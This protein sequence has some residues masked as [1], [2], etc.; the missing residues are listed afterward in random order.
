[1]AYEMRISDWSSDV[2][3]SDLPVNQIA[4][5]AISAIRIGN[6]SVAAAPFTAITSVARNRYPKITI[7]AISDSTQRQRAIADR[8]IRAT[9]PSSQAGSRACRERVW[10]YGS[11]SL[12]AGCIKKTLTKDRYRR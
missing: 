8:A 9:E 10:H 2:C 6:G 5:I 3:S 4:K 12:G 7:M 11:T 1:M